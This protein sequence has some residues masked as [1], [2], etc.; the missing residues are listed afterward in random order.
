LADKKIVIGVSVTTGNSEQELEKLRTAAV[1]FGKDGASSA[2]PLIR[3]FDNCS[4]A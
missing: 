4:A 3:Q 1:R 2:D